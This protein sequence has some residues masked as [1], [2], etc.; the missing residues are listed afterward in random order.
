MHIH[1]FSEDTPSAVIGTSSGS[2]LTKV[3][4]ALIS[5]YCFLQCHFPV[6]CPFA[7]SFC[8]RL[9]TSQTDL[10]FLFSPKSSSIRTKVTEEL[11]APD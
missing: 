6:S 10:T 8:F 3:G 1:F 5:Y 2:S 7:D 11:T 9:L 4:D